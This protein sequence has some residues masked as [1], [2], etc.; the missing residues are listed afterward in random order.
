MQDI[1]L[2]AEVGGK[3]LSILRSKENN[4]YLASWTEETQKAPRGNIEISVYDD[5]SYAAL[6]KAQRSG[7]EASAIKPLATVVLNHPVRQSVTYIASKLKQCLN[8]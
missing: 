8:N 2:Y 4:M 6:R 1:P 7:E 5:E 3:P